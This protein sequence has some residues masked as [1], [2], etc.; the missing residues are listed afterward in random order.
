MLKS[1]WLLAL[2]QLR[3]NRG[4]SFINIAGLATGMAVALVIG[5]WTADELAHDTSYPGHARIG[6]IMQGQKGGPWAKDKEKTFIGPTLSSALKPFLKKGYDD[7]FAQTALLSYPTE[8][9]LVAGDRSVS[10][11]GS[12]AEYSFPAIFGYR[13]LSGNAECLRDPS[14]A[15]VSQNTAIALFGSADAV[16]KTFKW[17]NRVPFRVGGVFASQPATSSFEDIDFFTSFAN[18]NNRGNRDNTDFANHGC[19]MFA[20]LAGNTTMEQATARVKNICTPHVEMDHE[21]YTVL[22]FESLYLHFDDNNGAIGQGR[23]SFVR[24]IGIIGIFVLLLACINFMNLSTARSEKRA[25]EV[26]IR[27]TIGSLRTQ[28]IAQFLGESVLVALLAFIGALILAAIS[29][30][31]FSEIAGKTMTI[32][33]TSPLFWALSLA[34]TLLTGLVA[35]S[36][37]AFYLSG[38][39][40]VK[41]LKGAF[42]A[43]KGAS[44]PRKVLVVCQ[45]SISLALIIG[46]IVVYRQIQLAKDRPLGYDQAGLITVPINTDSLDRHYEA[47]RTDLLATG[48]VANVA[49]ASQTTYHFD[50]NN[51]VEWAG[52]LPSQKA[53]F[54]RDVS[55]NADFGPTIGWT[56]LKGRDFSR[57][58]ATDSSAAI[59]NEEGARDLGFKDPLGKTVKYN[60]KTYTIIGVVKNMLTNDPY[61]PIQPAVF[62]GDGGHYAFTIRIKPGVPVRSALASIGSVFKKFNPAS[63][64]IYHFNDEEFEKKFQTETRIGSLATVFA[65]LAILISCL[66]LFGLA[67]FVAE[68]RTKEIG[69][70][71]V[72]GARVVGIWLLLSGDFVKLIIISMAIAMPLIGLAMQK[73]LQNYALH[74]NLSP[75]IF[76]LAGAGMLLITLATVSFQAVRAAFMNP[77]KSLRTE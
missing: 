4:Y 48:V 55:V 7:I 32:P 18:D 11:N 72:L 2:R 64:F 71:K 50:Q 16:G 75:Y 5:L 56:V 31:G 28:L 73:W 25:K 46:T 49:N 60:G 58:F 36:Y 77:I 74:T 61:S 8:H 44:T 62:L 9:L 43:G 66:G 39:R 29:L 63:P 33:W 42:K 65:V 1:Y 22:P 52:M 70:R 69:V 19:R 17:D 37:P 53:I 23:I 3:K 59:F 45:F 34:F 10:S 12:P 35:G 57:Q 30:P 67:S 14:S 6:E 41:V 40:P 13:F 26:G 27:K 24:L 76:L 38:F 20:R 54:F 68:Q 15:I 47:V 51:G 21:T